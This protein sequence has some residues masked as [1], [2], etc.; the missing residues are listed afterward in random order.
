MG[1]QVKVYRTLDMKDGANVTSST[2]TGTKIGTSTGQKFG[3]WNVTPVAQQGGL[4]QTY[5]TADGTLAALT[6]ATLTDSSSGTASTVIAAMTIGAASDST[7]C[8]NNVASLTTQ[9]N[10]LRADHADLA[11]FVNKVVDNLQTNGILG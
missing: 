8:V 1:Q 4:T 7:A 5:S 11:Q 9:L 3:F 2:S 6:S 10:A